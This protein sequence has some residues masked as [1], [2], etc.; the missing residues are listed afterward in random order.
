MRQQ[1]FRFILFDE[2]LLEF[3]HLLEMLQRF[4]TYNKY[5]KIERELQHIVKKT[6]KWC[7]KMQFIFN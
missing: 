4:F 2:N 1:R 6:K 5:N 3:T 7:A